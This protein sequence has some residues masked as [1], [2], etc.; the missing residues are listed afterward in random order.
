MPGV[1]MNMKCVSASTKACIVTGALGVPECVLHQR[2]LKFEDTWK[3]GGCFG[4][5]C[6]PVLLPKHSL[7]QT[8]LEG[9][10]VWPSMAIFLS[11]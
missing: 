6:C 7:P 3:V 9:P 4:H 10:S 2:V 8:E 5:L 11:R 1:D